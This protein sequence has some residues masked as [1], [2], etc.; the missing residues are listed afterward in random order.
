MTRSLHPNGAFPDKTSNLNPYD[1]SISY[2]F[3]TLVHIC[4]LS[5]A[6]SLFKGYQGPY[7]NRLWR[8]RHI[9]KRLHGRKRLWPSYGQRRNEKDSRV[10]QKSCS[11]HKIRKHWMCM[12]QSPKCSCCGHRECEGCSNKHGNFW[13]AYGLQ[14][15]FDIWLLGRHGGDSI[16]SKLWFSL[17]SK[18]VMG[19]T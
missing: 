9:C 1:S 3:C 12:C 5:S 14:P 8:V 4:C 2:S 16:S 11:W 18:S 6:R 17:K 15:S 19:K 10:F 13:K 7:C